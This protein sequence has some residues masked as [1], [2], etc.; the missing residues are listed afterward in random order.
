MDSTP[1]SARQEVPF[2][3]R[4]ELSSLNVNK[5][6]GASLASASR[7][8]DTQSMQNE[9]LASTQQATKQTSRTEVDSLEDSFKFA[10]GIAASAPQKATSKPT[11]SSAAG[12]T[13]TRA[14]NGGSN[15]FGGPSSFEVPEEVLLRDV[16][17]ALQAIDSRYLYF[18]AAA[19]R[20]QITRSVGVPTRTCRRQ[21]GGTTNCM[22][23]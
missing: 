9:R 18:D 4:P 19:D 2:V 10:V 11:T 16:L 3:T 14:S 21:R 20:F 8:P 22:V 12:A 17:Y 13:T 23:C 5:C 15:P 7:Y 6:S 1:P